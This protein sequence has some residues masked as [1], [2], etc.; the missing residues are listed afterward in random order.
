MHNPDAHKFLLRIPQDIKKEVQNKAKQNRLSLNQWI[1]QAIE[2][3]IAKDGQLT[4]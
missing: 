2:E 4:N 1:V 3:K